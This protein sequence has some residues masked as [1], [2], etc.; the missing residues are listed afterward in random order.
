[1]NNLTR[2]TEMFNHFSWHRDN[3]FTIA[4]TIGVLHNSLIIHRTPLF[5]YV[6]FEHNL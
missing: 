6:C 4:Y 2:H 5:T 1:M 3:R